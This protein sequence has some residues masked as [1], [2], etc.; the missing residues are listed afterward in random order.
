MEGRNVG[1]II[2]VSPKQGLVSAKDLTIALHGRG[3]SSYHKLD[4][5]T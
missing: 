2:G 4:L 3:Q 5:P 1:I